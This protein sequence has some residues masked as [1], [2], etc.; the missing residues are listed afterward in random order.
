MKAHR[1][2]I[3]TFIPE[4][5]PPNSNVAIGNNCNK[6]KEIIVLFKQSTGNL[7]TYPV[8]TKQALYKLSMYTFYR[9]NSRK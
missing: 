2:L 1:N 6:L 4:I 3:V 5:K 9:R 7:S 8:F